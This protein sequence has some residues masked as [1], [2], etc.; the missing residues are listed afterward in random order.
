MLESGQLAAW[1]ADGRLAGIASFAFDRD[2]PAGLSP[3][4]VRDVRPL[5]QAG[6]PT[7]EILERLIVTRVRSIADLLLPL[8]DRTSGAAGFISF[9]LQPLPTA[10]AGTILDAARRVWERINRPNVLLRLPASPEAALVVEAAT[11][12]G[13]NLHITAVGTLERY[14]EI[15][16][17]YVRG[18]EVRQAR[19]DSVDHLASIITLDLAGLD[20]AVER[21][22]DQVARRDPKAAARA[23]S[24]TDRAGRAFARLAVA[25]AWAVR[26]SAAFRRLAERGARPQ[27]PLIAGLGVDPKP[28]AGR[29]HD[30]PVPGAGYLIALEA[31]GL[32]AL[33][34]GG[35]VEPLPESDMAAPRAELDALGALG[36][37]WAEVSEQL[38]QRALHESVHTH[39]GQ[40][41]AAGRMAA[42]V[43]HELGDLLPRVRETLEQLVAGAVVRRIWDR[44]ESLWA[45]GGPGAAEVRRRMGWLTLPDEM[46][47]ALEGIHALATEARDDGLS[48]VVL[49]GM[50]GSSLASD[51]M[52]R[53]LRG[54][55]A[56]MDLTVLDSTDPAAVVRVTHR[57]PCQKTLFLVASKSGTTAEPLA[58]FEHFWARTVE[59]LGERAGR[60][61]VA[62][63]DPGTP[64]ERLAR[65]RRFRAVVATPENVGGRYSALSE[66]G[67]LPA[68]LLG[69]DL[70]ALLHGGAQMMR[71]CGPESPTLENPGLFLGAILAAAMEAGKDK[72]TLVADPPLAPFGDWIEQLLA[73]SSGKEGKGIVPIVGEPPGTGRHYGT[74]RLLVYLRFDGSLDGKAAGWVRAGIPVIVLET[75]GGPAGL[76]A[77]FY[78]WEFATAVACHGL[79]VNA[80]DQPDVQRAKT[81]TM[82]LLKAYARTRSLPEPRPLW[83]SESVTLQ[84]GPDLPGLNSASGLSEVVECIASQIRFHETFAL[85]LYLAPGRAWGRP[86][87]ALRRNLREA[88]IVSTVGFGPR[89][90]HSTGQLHK[91]G[92]DRMVFLMVT[93]DPAE[94]LAVP[95]AAYTFGVLE[96]AQAMGDL[97]AL[98][99]LG[100]RAYALHLRSPD[101]AAVVLRTLA[102]IGGA[103]RTGTA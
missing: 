45:A 72:V 36:V 22:L 20:A 69:I 61:F 43:Q 67:L 14:A 26:S 80:F 19:G 65:D 64:L 8:Y 71:A 49:L 28:G 17:A 21:Q 73:E 86:L 77:E 83:Q 13:L 87:A 101:E 68:A 66:F 70:R 4:C 84:G 15:A 74:D 48:G 52:S 2:N 10:A 11:A 78:R 27:L 59:K 1:I 90:L 32:G 99:G 6:R 85:L 103:H 42:R 35:R 29:S 62:L 98:V 37:S 24:L 41:R 63:T 53:V 39:Q 51:V 76:G 89:Y 91:G 40:L 30:A 92:P 16:D 55:S 9:D 23:R 46:L 88:G 38:E 97:Q 79:G 25:Q 7:P 18:L 47:A 44:D 102:A 31:E 96:H 100:R 56:A 34:D 94:D 93:A 33:A 12:D 82:D 3:S 57:H 81:R 95:G 75:S 54:D 60:H 5:A 58:L 50:G